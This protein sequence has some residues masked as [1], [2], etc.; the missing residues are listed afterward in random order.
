MAERR[1][2]LELYP[3]KYKVKNI[4]ETVHIQACVLEL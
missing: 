3:S 4:D 1:I 2:E